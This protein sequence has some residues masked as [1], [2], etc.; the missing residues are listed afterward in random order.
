MSDML[1]EVANA[2][3]WDCAIPRHRVTAEVVDGMVT[4][5]G[6]VER[7]YQKSCAEA[8]VRRVPGV[9]G[10]NNEIA[11]AA[12]TISTKAATPASAGLGYSPQVR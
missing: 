2:L 11:L 1:S 6:L 3:Y 12:T 9:I 10:V 8:T 4:L 7:P 5:R